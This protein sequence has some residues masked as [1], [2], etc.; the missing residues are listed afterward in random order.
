MKSKK[1]ETPVK[2][3]R[4]DG[5]ERLCGKLNGIY[6]ETFTGDSKVTSF[7]YVIPEIGEVLESTKF[8]CKATS[9]GRECK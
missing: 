9:I 7:H 6:T 1:Q 4:L 5:Y 3:R 2:N 8:I